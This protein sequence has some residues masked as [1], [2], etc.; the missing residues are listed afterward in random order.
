M[1][2]SQW[3]DSVHFMERLVGKLPVVTQSS[4]MNEIVRSKLLQAP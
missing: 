3:T 2:W 4:H 1:R